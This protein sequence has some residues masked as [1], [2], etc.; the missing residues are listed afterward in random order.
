[1]SVFGRLHMPSLDSAAESLNS[2]RLRPAGLRA[3]N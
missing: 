1:M 2:E 3:E